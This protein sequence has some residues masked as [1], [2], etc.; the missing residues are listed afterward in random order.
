MASKSFDV[1]IVGA[2]PAGSACAIRCA[3]AGLKV[4]VIERAVF[5]R[6]K[7]CGDCINPGCWPILERL[8]VAHR[9][10]ELPH[11]SLAEVR[12]VSLSGEAI[13]FP[14][15]AS[16]HG[17]IAMKRAYFDNLLLERAIECG[18]EVRQGTTVTAIERGW[19][20]QTGEASFSSPVVVAADG[21]NSSVT[22]MLGLFPKT[23][24]DRVGLQT[25]MEAPLG[26]GDRVV[27]RF[28]REGY[29]GVASVGGDELNLCLVARPENAEALKGWAARNFSIPHGIAWRTVT[30]LTRRPVD[31]LHENLLLVGDA[32]RVVEPF[33]GEGIFYALSS[34]EL[35]A[36]HICGELP[37]SE[38]RKNHAAL[39]AG[40]LWVNRL[41]REAVLH[42]RV[43]SFALDVLSHQPKILKLLTKKVVGKAVR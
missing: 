38:Y 24:K 13:A 40:R 23:V 35:A 34:G 7:V 32:A 29:C 41:A 17:E 42:P 33:T 37:F 28:V 25:H 4:L 15:D 3:Q 8:G 14:L 30:P 43:G 31:P 27:L 2:G 11:S 1:I 9:M 12:F 21:R 6:E 39:Y 36:R 22:R 5:P 19:K 26:F 16:A 20:V 18:A 10:F